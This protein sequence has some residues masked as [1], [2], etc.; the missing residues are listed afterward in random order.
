[1]SAACLRFVFL[2]CVVVLAGSASA[3]ADSVVEIAGALPKTGTLGLAQLEAMRPAKETWTIEGE[4]REVT[5][6]PLERVLTHFGFEPGPMGKDV[7]KHEKR[8]GWRKAIVASAADGFSAVLSAAEV[9]E[10]MGATRA[11]IAWKIDGKPLPAERGPFRLVV[12]TDKEPSRSIYGLRKIEVLDLRGTAGA[13]GPRRPNVLWLIAEDLGP[14]L[15]AYGTKEVS[16]P[17]LDRLASEGMRFTRAF[18]TA[19]VCSPSR[20]AFMTGMYQTT[21]GAH[22]HRSH[23][24]DGFELPAGVRVLTDR[25]RDAGYFTANVVELPAPAGFKG[26]GKTD[27]NFT[28]DG[29]R[30]DS[31]RWQDLAAHQPFFAQ[32][33]F[34]ET[35]RAFRA[36]KRADPSKVAIPPYYPDHPVTRAD[37]AAYLDAATELDRK[38]GVILEQLRRDGLADDTVVFFFADNGQAHVRGKQFPYDSGLSV[39]LIIRWPK[40]F[41]PPRG[42]RPGRVDGRLVASIDFAPTVLAIAGAAKP[43]T[44]EGRILFGPGAEP[45]RKYVFGARD[46]CDETVFRFRTV[47]DER[48]RFIRNFTPDR[49]FLQPNDYKE[50]SY[51]VWNLLKELGSQGKLTAAQA[52]LTAPT[53]P[54][55]ELYD[56]DRDPHEVSNLVGSRQAH[57]QAALSRL[58]R[59]LHTWIEE[60]NDQGRVLEPAEIAAAKGVTTKA[61]DPSSNPASGNRVK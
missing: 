21:I 6:V 32:V 13:R 61:P 45:P 27:W 56:L 48:Y 44:M 59:A 47:R 14:H 16:T 4:R 49:P 30:F 33:N 19:P 42:F 7:P 38:T 43:A 25:M 60:S 5:G 29:A 11:M 22:N 57:H 12:L 23:R 55:E 52:T 40:S 39:P 17:N 10:A 58:R 41:P 9:F 1:M 24:D 31:S 37:W 3:H 2:P 34:S 28:T 51:P 35:H 15:G 46:R 8:S 50:R 26:T 54:P 53:M 36:P 20:S 18:A